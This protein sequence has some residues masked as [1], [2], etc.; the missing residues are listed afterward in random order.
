[1]TGRLLSFIFIIMSINSVPVFAQTT[2]TKGTSNP[3]LDL[4]ASGSWDDVSVILPSVILETGT[5]KMWYHGDD[6]SAT[7]IGYATSSDGV[8][9]SKSSSN[10]VLGLGAAGSWDDE[11]ILEPTVLFDGSNYHMWYQGFDGNTRRIGYAT[12]SD[13]IAWNKSTSNPVLGLGSAGSWDSAELRQTFVILEEGLFRMWYTGSDGSIQQFGYATS[14]DGIN[15]TKYTGNPTMGR[16]AAGTWDDVWIASQRVIM[17]GSLYEMLY[18]A[19]DGSNVRIGYATSSDGLA[20]T[21]YN[22]NPVINQGSTGTWDDRFLFVGSVIKID[23]NYNLWY[24]GFDGVT[25]RIGYATSIDATVS[26]QLSEP[27]LKT[28]SLS[29]NFPNPFNPETRIDYSLSRQSEVRLTIYNIAGREVA[30]LVKSEQDA[31]N[32]S[33]TWDASNVASGI[34]FYRLQAGD[35]VQTRKMVLLK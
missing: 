1:M 16:G 3:V 23:A 22:G 30:Q 13:G 4:G 8:T 7:R 6:G 17:N 2:W 29:Q 14:T 18:S 19:F 26:V 31:G 9:W 20:W 34:Y 27:L 24:G 28:F 21:K 32:F 12:S 11:A 5:F 10:P 35:L 33:I 15:W 25:W